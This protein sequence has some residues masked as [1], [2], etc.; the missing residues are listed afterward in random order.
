MTLRIKR[1][2]SVYIKQY[3]AAEDIRLAFSILMPYI[4]R[5]WKAYVSLFAFMWIDISL[6]L[7]YAWF[8]GAVT[9]AA[10]HS[11]FHRLKWLV[12]LGGLFLLLSVGSTYFG[13]YAET[14]SETGVKN[15]LKA[16]LLKHILLLPFNTISNLRSGD[17]LSHFTNDIHAIDGVIGSSLMN[18]IRLPFIYLAVFIYLMQINWTLSLISF[19]VAPAALLAGAV[20]GL[21][22]RRNSRLIQSLL[23]NMNTLLSEIFHGYLVIRSFTMEKSAFKRFT[24]QNREL[25]SLELQNAKLRGLFHTGGYAISSIIFLL[26]LS[27][28]A[29]FISIKV[30]SVGALLTFINLVDHLIYPLT[31][32][33]G[34][35]ANLQRSVAAVERL[36]KVLKQTPES[37]RM[38]IYY[39]SMPSIRTIHL[40]NVTFSYDSRNPIFDQFHLQIPAGK[41]VAIVGPSGAGKTTLFNLL[42]GF[43]KPQAGAIWINGSRTD[44]YST[45]QLRSFFAYVPQETFL[46]TGT[47]R[48]NLMLARP[49]ITEMSLV[50]AAEAANI[51]PFICSLPEGYETKIGE[52]GVQLSGGQKQRL[53]IARALLKDA[54]ILLLDEATS[55]LDN[56]TEYQVKEALGRLMSNR[57]TL[58]IAHR[59]STIRNADLIIVLDQ[60]QIVQMGRHE[61]LIDEDGLYRNLNQVQGHNREGAMVS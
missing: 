7:A 20:F 49:G 47:I 38:P 46:F 10:I 26:S 1:I 35:W 60:G 4:L 15:D 23:G 61:E 16:D 53:A 19:L 8:F 52:G 21:L 12:P 33:A 45:S 22:L 14:I 43:Y 24:E 42:Q 59:L 25:L 48:E 28:G 13:N 9:D 32:L 41:I 37:P 56:E 54:P 29:Y 27:V 11:D 17:L 36:S 58:V 31:G 30:M 18:L 34:Q 5:Q 40:Q 2:S 55:A 51:H 6:T 39:S 50:Q 44:K 57:T 3:F